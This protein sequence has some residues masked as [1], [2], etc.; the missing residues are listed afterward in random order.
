MLKQTCQIPG[1]GPNP[2]KLSKHYIIL[3]GSAT[4]YVT[5][6]NTFH[7]IKLSRLPQKSPYF[8]NFTEF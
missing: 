8:C 3:Q 5:H 6:Q 1:S 2:T 7:F 4:T